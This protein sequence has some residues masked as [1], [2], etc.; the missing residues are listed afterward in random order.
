MAQKDYYYI[1]ADGNYCELS[2]GNLLHQ[3]K[4]EKHLLDFALNPKEKDKVKKVKKIKKL[5]DGVVIE[6]DQD[7]VTCPE[8]FDLSE[9]V[10][11]VAK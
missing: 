3:A 9:D 5:Q 1:D 10:N 4:I 7:F 2:T 11:E 8:P 6:V